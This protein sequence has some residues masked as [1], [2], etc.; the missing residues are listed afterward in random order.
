[1]SVYSVDKL[2]TQARN[3]ASEYRKTTGKILPGVSNEIAEYDA[4]RLLNLQLCQDRSNSVDAI[5]LGSR[6]GMTIQIKARTIFDESKSGQRIG[7]IKL[8]KEWDLIILV[9][10]DAEYQP[11]EIY[12]AKRE[13]IV[14]YIADSSVNQRK[15]GAL[16][17]ARFRII[18]ELVWTKENGLEAQV[19]DNNA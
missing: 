13:D 1:M 12:E 7:Q 17:I 16:S 6:D 11:F 2:I 5:G 14:N 8:D 9:L 18:G 4:S 3:L 10:M 15:R 19:W